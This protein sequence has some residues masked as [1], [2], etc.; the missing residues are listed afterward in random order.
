[1][2]QFPNPDQTWKP[3]E[4]G[5][6]AGKPKGAKHLSTWIQE[7]M[8]DEQFEAMLPDVKEGWKTY[9]G[10]PMQAIIKTMAL[11]A[12]NGDVKAFDALA[13]YGYGTKMDVT[14]MGE[15]IVI[16]ILG[17]VTQNGVRRDDSP[18]QTPST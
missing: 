7:L 11:K 12:M 2:G 18:T 14:S 17:G 8:N 3:G 15:K 9:K 4:S 16:P 10:A 1:V 13:K 6:P 5:N